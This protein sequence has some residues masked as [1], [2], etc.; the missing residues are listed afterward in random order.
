MPKSKIS[1]GTQCVHNH[2]YANAQLTNQPI[3]TSPAGQVH[4]HVVPLGLQHAGDGN[5]LRPVPQPVRSIGV[6]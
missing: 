1:Q 2:N 6:N 4:S 5:T 3:T